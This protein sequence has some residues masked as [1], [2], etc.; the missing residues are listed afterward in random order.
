MCQV[1]LE[2]SNEHD[3][4]IRTMTCSDMCQVNLE[5]SNEHD[6]LIRTMT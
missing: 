4:L 3:W 1:N 5:W 2:W 6:W